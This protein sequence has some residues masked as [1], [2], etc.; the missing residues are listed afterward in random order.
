MNA[1]A[2]SRRGCS[3]IV[4]VLISHGSAKR[5]RR[6]SSVSAVMPCISRT[7]TFQVRDQDL[8]F[9]HAFIA[10]PLATCSSEYRQF[11]CG[12]NGCPICLGQM[13]DQMPG[14]WLMGL[15]WL[16]CRGLDRGFAWHEVAPLEPSVHAWASDSCYCLSG[17][18]QLSKAGQL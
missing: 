8:L 7:R 6:R 17:Q 4:T 16:H 5:C 3:G 1:L 11:A 12:C 15:C 9:G 10:N 13:H 14:C 18:D 2:A